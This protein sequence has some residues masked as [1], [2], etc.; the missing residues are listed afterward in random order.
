MITQ[1]EIEQWLEEG[2]IAAKAGQREQARWRLLDVVE[3]DQTNETAWF[4]L[5]QVFDRPEDK[6]VCLENLI[7]INSANV[8]AKQE[9]QHYVAPAPPA[10]TVAKARSSGKRQRHT[11]PRPLALKLISAFWL[12]ISLILLGGGIIALS[13][14]LAST[15]RSRTFPNFITALQAIEL[16][17]ALTLVVA[18]FV[19]LN[20]AIG[21]YLRSGFGFYGSL[22]LALALLLMGPMVSLIARPPNYVA[23]ICL[24]GMAGMM[25]LL[26]LASH[27]SLQISQQDHERSTG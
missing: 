11:S 6:R 10:P 23:A 15:L 8:W 1:H 19:G 2:I 24:G 26:T 14:W 18:G 7:I 5:Y 16:V 22:F 4:W 13:E 9:L 27:P 25:A 12:G 17:V 20:V 21:L 3:Q